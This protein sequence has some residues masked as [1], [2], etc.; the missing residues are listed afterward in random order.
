[1]RGIVVIVPRGRF[2]SFFSLPLPCS[3][4]LLLLWLVPMFS[5]ER[6]GGVRGGFMVGERYTQCV[7]G[8]QHRTPCGG[9]GCG[10]IPLYCG[11]VLSNCDGSCCGLRVLASL[12]LYKCHRM[13]HA[14]FPSS[15]HFTYMLIRPSHYEDTTTALVNAACR[16]WYLV[17]GCPVRWPSLSS[18]WLPL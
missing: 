4:R 14:R 3:F 10:S 13:G 8:D 18:S 6:C 2:V 11:V 12:L 5:S 1:M 17:L 15:R 9:C 16:M 7:V